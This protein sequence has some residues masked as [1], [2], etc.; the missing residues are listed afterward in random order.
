M[1]KRR[2]VLVL[3]SDEHRADVAGFAGDEVIRTPTLDWLAETGTVFDNAYTPS[4]ICVPARQ[5][6]LAGQYPRT[7][8]C[9]GWVGLADGYMTYARRFGQYGY[10]T[11]AFG[12]LHL[13]GQDQLEGWQSRPVGDVSCGHV[14]GL[15]ENFFDGF[16]APQD[17]P[18]NPGSVKWSDEKELRRAAP[19]RQ[20]DRK[21]ELTVLGA[22]DWI[23][24]NFVGTWYDRHI[25]QRP[26][27]MY[28]GLINP[29][30]PYQCDEKLFRYYLPRVRGFEVESP[31]DHPFMGKSA[32]PKVPTEA[33]KDVPARAVQRARAAYY[34]KVE[35]MDTHFGRVLDALRFAGQDP[36]DWII[37]YC[38]D[39]GDQLGEHGIWEKQ[40]FYEGSVRVPLII[41]APGL[42]PQ[43]TRIDG[44][45]S[46]CD[47]FATLCDLADI[48]TPASLDSRSLVPP[49][50]GEREDWPDEA[51]SFFLQQ[52]YTNVMIKQ[53]S[54]KYQWY[55]HE[56]D[57][58]LPEI[59]FDLAKDPHETVNLI[60]DQ[61][62]ADRVQRFRRR[63]AELG[64]G[65]DACE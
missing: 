51:C 20:I 60:E 33:G 55:E 35:T 25:P 14:E 9:E 39:H 38:S 7:C 64:Y 3:I 63:L 12:K 30:Y 21:D 27:M 24:D 52:G 62:Y 49:A 29:H 2:N 31:L 8:G 48:E 26:R 15:R 58:V 45:V 11:A 65:P 40:K 16:Q 34:G 1:S 17:D 53:G 46:L 22:E 32:W 54:L 28:V 36:D 5:C 19:G 10:Q 42:M 44:N 13:Q 59:L 43:G 47:L 37:V 50:N 18:L 56:D 61:A 23:D 4:P 41:R 6:V 57:G